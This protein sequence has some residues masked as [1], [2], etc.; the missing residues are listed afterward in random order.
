MHTFL[1]IVRDRFVSAWFFVKP[2][3]I[4]ISFLFHRAPIGLFRTF[5][6]GYVVSARLFA[7]DETLH[8]LHGHL[9]S[10]RIQF[11]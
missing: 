3:A 7:L 2:A 9:R 8:A 5:P 4:I 11:H 6:R 1:F 10:P